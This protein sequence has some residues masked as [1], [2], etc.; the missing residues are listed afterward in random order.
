ME[1]LDPVQIERELELEL[2]VATGTDH[3]ISFV[4]PTGHR[5]RYVRVRLRELLSGF[6]G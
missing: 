5:C 6:R 1:P 3:G 2:V 4:R